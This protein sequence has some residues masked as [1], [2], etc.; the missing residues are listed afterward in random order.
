[1]KN[2]DDVLGELGLPDLWL[3]ALAAKEEK[4]WGAAAV[5]IMRRVRASG[6]LD[7][8]GNV[9]IPFGRFAGRFVDEVC[10]SDPV[11]ATWLERNS[12]VPA[13]VRIA[14]AW[15]RE[16]TPIPKMRT[17]EEDRAIWNGEVM[18]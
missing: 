6:L 13:H 9:L 3:M 15:Q 5:E 11:Q 16:V 2:N 12:R 4:E 14:L 10:A 8:P 17:T 7:A 18:P 1:M